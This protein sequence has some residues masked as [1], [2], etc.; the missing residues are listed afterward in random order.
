MPP[1]KDEIV[2]EEGTTMTFQCPTLNSTNYT[3]WAVKIKAIFNVHGIWEAIEP[4]EEGDKEVDKTKNA[5][6][7]A[8][9]FQAMPEE[10]VFQIAHHTYAKDIWE[11]L[12]ARYVGEDKV[13]EARM[14]T[15]ESEFEALKMKDSETLDD[16]TDKISKL[17]SQA[18]NLGST[19]DNKR[20]VRKLLGSVPEK[21]I[22]I[23]AAIEQFADLKTM[24]FQE[25]IGRLKA[26]EE[27]IKKPTEEGDI[28]G[29]L[30]LT[31]EEPKEK[32]KEDKCEHCGSWKPNQGSQARGQNK[33]WKTWKNNATKRYQ[34]NKSHIRCYNCNK[35]GHLK[36]E[37]R[38]LK[39]N[40]EAHLIQCEEDGQMLI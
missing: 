11:D 14:Q 17:V 40:D 15:L 6:A 20:L 26:Y 30:L 33:N 32:A 39:E 25:A 21:Y 38:K 34:Q 13:K 4:S 5:K 1:K 10:L 28:H 2:K 29:K 16:F 37:C 3:I 19:I 24:Q 8:Y 31:K 35:F 18:N 7:V 22:Q 12:K 27:R 23:V 36:H 9:L